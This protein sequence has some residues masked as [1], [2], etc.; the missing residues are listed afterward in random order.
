MTPGQAVPSDP[1]WGAALAQ[2]LNQL[3]LELDA[4]QQS[5]LLQYLGLLTKW[6]QVYNLTAVR[7]PMD[8]LRQHLLDSLAVVPALTRH[9]Q[10]RGIVDPIPLLD[11][12]AGAGL[13]GVAL[14]V[15]LP[16]LRVTCVDTVG[17]KVA[18]I[19]QVAA[20]LRLENLKTRHARVETLTGH[21]WP[22]I[23]SRAFASLAEFTGWTRQA[24]AP[25]GVWI[26]MKGREPVEEMRALADSVRVFHVEP[27]QVPGLDAQ[28]CLVWM[29]ESRP[30]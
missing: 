2:G 20:T 17:K 11:V 10:S 15:A 4:Q 19:Q 8:M 22:I 25:G 9:L 6:N 18:F 26:A 12:G 21:D 24:L 7:D 30:E 29:R 14:A 16:Q 1:A 5:D 27:L 23:C 3:R 13:P 28:R